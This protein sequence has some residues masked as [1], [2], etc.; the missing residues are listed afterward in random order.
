M[1]TT[2]LSQRACF[3]TFLEATRTTSFTIFI[4]SV[5][6]LASNPQNQNQKYSIFSAI[7]I[8]FTRVVRHDKNILKKYQKHYIDSNQRGLYTHFMCKKTYGFVLSSN[9][10][11]FVHK[12]A[13]TFG[14][15]Y[16]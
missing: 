1:Q 8:L 9:L 11:K 16:V 5:H 12:L 6:I 10:H 7:R 2:E 3:I 13:M 14:T 4:R 15:L